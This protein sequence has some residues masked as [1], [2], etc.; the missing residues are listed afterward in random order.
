MKKTTLKIGDEVTC[1]TDTPAY[2]SKYAGNPEVLFRPGMTGLVAAIKV[3]AVTGRKPTFTCV[4]FIGPPVGNPANNVWR[5]A[6]FPGNIVLVE[7]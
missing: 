1:K 3:P 6:L 4:D 2:Y 7:K 5:V